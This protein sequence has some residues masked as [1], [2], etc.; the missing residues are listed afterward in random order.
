MA[1]NPFIDLIDVAVRNLDDVGI[2]YAVTGSVASGIHGEPITSWDV[3]IVVLMS[4]SQASQLADVLPQRFYRS[5]EAL[6][7]AARTFGMTNLIDTETGLKVDLACMRP[8]PY[9]ASV[10]ARRVKAS[11]GPDEPEFDAVSPEDIILMKLDWRRESQ[12]QKQW[13]N[14]L[15]VACVKGASLDWKYLFEQARE[16]DLEDDLIK[17]RDEAGI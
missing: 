12:S 6:E 8:T 7:Q 14:A 1:D 10:F 4:E 9:R 2:T 13:D 3:D 17:L 16:L 11:L 15:S 5:K